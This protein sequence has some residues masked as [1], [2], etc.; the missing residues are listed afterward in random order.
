MSLLNVGARALQANQVGLQTAGHNIANVNTPGYS[1]QTVSLETVQGRYTGDGY[2]GQGVDV[3]AILRSHSELLTRQAAS[4]AAVKAGDNARLD[5]LAQLQ[6]VFSGGPSGLGGAINDMMN[7]LSGVANAPTDMTARN[8]VLTR[9][10]ETAVR[11]RGAAERLDEMGNSVNEQIHGSLAQ[12]NS[13][14]KSI[15]AVNAQ[16]VEAKGNGQSPNDLLDQRDQLIRGLNV[17]IQ[18]TQ[19][20]ADDGSIGVFVSSS[21][22]LVLGSMAATLSLGAPDAFPTSKTQQQLFFSMPGTAKPIELN[23]TMLGGGTIAGLLQFQNSDLAEGQNLLGR[24]AL[25]ISETLNTQNKLGLTLD[26]NAGGNLFK[27]LALAN[28]VT[29]KNNAL[30][31]KMMGLEVADPSKLYAS[32][33]DITFTGPTSGTVTRQSDGKLFDFT[34]ITE[35]ET[36][37]LGEGLKLTDGA[38]PSGPFAGANN[39]DQFLLN[40]MQGLAGQMQA[41]Q[42]SPRNL[43]AANPINAAMGTTNAGSLQLASL[44]ATG[45]NLGALGFVAPPSP[46]LPATTGGGVTLTFQAGPPNTFTTTRVPLDVSTNPPTA[47][48]PAGGPYTYTPGQPISIDGWEITLQGSPKDG[49]TVTVGNASDAQY[50]DWYTRDA[51]NAGAML[52]LRDKA[53]FDGATLA[54]GFAGAMAQIGTRTQSAMFAANLSTAI[55]DNLEQDRTAIAGVN[56]DEE[57]A[58]LIQYQQAY[59]ASAKMLSIAQNIFDNLMQ[60]VGR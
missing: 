59:Q 1:R 17:H 58:R 32:S 47:M 33:Y 3:Q 56:L 41:Q 26:G 2:I 5:R 54:D 49:D 28:A 7:A 27:P 52:A 60:S 18:T 25:G 13:L 37:M 6:D 55:A 12:V 51:G 22:P 24:L 48:T 34:T 38:T 11:L 44:R 30:P 16:I 45:I 40:P 9:M 42:Y 35:L 19:I 4:A 31:L 8:V 39:K 53:L 50:G 21:Q 43:A 46:V 20:A 29:G 23:Q 15:A 57:A 36:V 10:E 14:A